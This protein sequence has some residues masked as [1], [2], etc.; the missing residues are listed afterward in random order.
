MQHLLVTHDSTITAKLELQQHRR[1]TPPRGTPIVSRTRSPTPKHKHIMNPRGS[2]DSSAPPQTNSFNNCRSSVEACGP[3]SR[4][5]PLAGSSVPSAPFP[6]GV[7]GAEQPFPRVRQAQGP[8]GVVAPRTFSHGCSPSGDA[9]FSGSLRRRLLRI[10]AVGA[11]LL[12]VGPL[13]GCP[14]PA[15]RGEPCLQAT[16][17]PA[18][19]DKLCHSTCWCALT[20]RAGRGDGAHRIAGASASI[21]AAAMAVSA[22]RPV[23][24]QKDLEVASAAGTVTSQHEVAKRN[25]IAQLAHPASV[26]PVSSLAHACSC[27]VGQLIGMDT[28]RIATHLV[29]RGKPS[30]WVAS[31]VRDLH[32]VWI[33]LMTWLE[34]HDI[35]HDGR[36]VDAVSLGEFL[37]EVDSGAR[38]KADAN[39]LRAEASDA[40]AAGR[41]AR[42]GEPP[43][44]PKRWQ[45][46][47]HAEQAVVTKLKMM[48]N[49]FG[50][51]LP[52]E[53]A[54]ASR[55]PGVRPRMPTPSLTIG[56]V[57]RLHEFVESVATARER[58]E[59]VSIGRMA[60][61]SVSAGLL[62]ACFSCNRCEQANSCFFAGE[63]GG[64]LH[65]VLTLDKN[66]N[67]DKR[68]ARPFWMRIA[69]PGGSAK[70]F[71]FLKNVLRGTEGGCFV[72]RDFAGSEGGDPAEATAFMGSP[73]QG[74]RLV[75]AIVC[76]LSRVCGIPEVDAERWAKHS[77]RH[78]LM[79]CS[80]ARGVHSLRAF[81]IGRWGGSTAQDP[82]LTPSER[83]QRRHQLVAGV[84]PES[85]A[86][87][88]KVTRVCEILGDE[89]AVLDA[90]WDR[91]AGCPLGVRSIPVFGSF[92]V[93]RE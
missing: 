76:V 27:D 81:E 2:D 39:K 30:K 11:S 42:R 35:E 74:R 12:R 46:G 17:P 64:Y 40:E 53:R 16:R 75:R 62:F 44:P 73:L 92:D 84:M 66:P 70:W 34:R 48:N 28:S 47:S 19:C 15:E 90:L 80:G 67:P 7:R 82:D 77:C 9:S 3:A 55:A 88:A 23:L 63:V 31:T 4:R 87:A 61:A 6:Y 18:S 36:A 89:M 71:S 29:S 78:F 26:L 24:S 60:H 72:F 50:T 20:G 43:P 69:G 1:G 56:M 86:P 79:E 93:L 54:R 38:A 45:D 21:G 85:Y 65:G 25:L 33:R 58:S 83:L 10:L 14:G 52:L 51:D 13:A 5:S 22:A 49:H 32:N 41:A 91:A 68:Q 37:S 8:G 57:F 59:V